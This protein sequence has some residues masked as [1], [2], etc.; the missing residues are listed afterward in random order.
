MPLN[1]VLA[2]MKNAKYFDEV[3]DYI[4]IP[5]AEDCLNALEQ[6]LI[7]HYHK[8][9][10]IY[11]VNIFELND[12]DQYIMLL[13]SD[14]CF[15]NLSIRMGITEHEMEEI[16][17]A[18]RNAT[19]HMISSCCSPA[20]YLLVDMSISRKE[21]TWSKFVEKLS[22]PILINKTSAF[23]TG[24]PAHS[25]DVGSELNMYLLLLEDFATSKNQLLDLDSM[26]NSKEAVRQI[27]CTWRNLINHESDELALRSETPWDKHLISLFPEIPTALPDFYDLKIADTYTFF[28]LWE[29]IKQRLPNKDRVKLI[30][31]LTNAYEELSGNKSL[32]IPWL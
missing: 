23:I 30:E 19:E 21:E 12:L 1:D 22:D 24:I 7:N 31:L 3:I 20:E 17:S 29:C 8:T 25:H 16:Q 32:N 11:S 5:A 27:I 28:G 2:Q 10:V 15:T 9:K 18:A 14:W 6:L 13:S 4:N 26:G